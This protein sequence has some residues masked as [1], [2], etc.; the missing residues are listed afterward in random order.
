M[1]ASKRTATTASSRSSTVDAVMRISRALSRK[2]GSLAFAPPVAF[3]YNPL[4]YA[5]APHERYLANARKGIDAL[6]LGMNPGPFGMA[7]TGVPFGEVAAVRGFLGIDERVRAPQATHP[8]R[9]I[10]G[11]ACS[12][13]EVSGRRF[14]GLMAREFGTP[15]RFFAHG[16]VWNW[17]PLAFMAESGANLTPDKLPRAERDGIESA[18]DD[19]LRAIAEALSPRV[20]VGVG[21]FASK[22]AER[23]LGERAPEILTMLHPSPASP[24]ANRGWDAEA[25]KVLLRVRKAD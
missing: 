20:V 6:Y 1:A 14:W 22:C 25:R 18:C 17:C 11:F 8:K 13:S 10:E 15:E 9:P 5:R 24:A 16:F 23:A 2:V 21:A 4:D 12:R 7:Q 3:V 19:A